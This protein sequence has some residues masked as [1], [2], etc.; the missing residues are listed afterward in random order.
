VH[1][2]FNFFLRFWSVCSH[3]YFKKLVL[4]PWS[5]APYTV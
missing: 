4:R 1:Y 5:N 2:L 3:K